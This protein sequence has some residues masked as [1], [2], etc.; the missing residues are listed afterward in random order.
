MLSIYALL[1]ARYISVSLDFI[2]VGCSLLYVVPY[3][4]EPFATRRKLQDIQ[5]QFSLPVSQSSQ[6]LSVISD[7]TIT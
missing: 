5:N 2:Y 7:Q 4:I 6:Q 3:L 1:T